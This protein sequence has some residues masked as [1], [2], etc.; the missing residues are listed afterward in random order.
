MHKVN[1]VGL[2]GIVHLPLEP[3][4]NHLKIN[5]DTCDILSKYFVPELFLIFLEQELPLNMCFMYLKS[6][7]TRRQDEEL[8]SLISNF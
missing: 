2:F 1:L 3:I 6:F 4:E 8:T 5:P 7:G